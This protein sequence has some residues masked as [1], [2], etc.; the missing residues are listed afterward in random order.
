MKTKVAAMRKLV[1][2][3]TPERVS[4][5]GACLYHAIAARMILG[6]ECLILA[7]NASWKFTT[8]DDGTNPTHFSYVYTPGIYVPGSVMPEMHVWNYYEGKMLDITTCYW[9]A[10]C[11]KLIGEEFSQSLIPPDFHYGA[12]A[13]ETGLWYYEPSKDATQLAIQM[14][15]AIAREA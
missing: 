13:E 3:I 8:F 6:R 10:Q 12:A 7:G 15:N 1:K 5:E 4:L 11:L 14:L 2:Q 9:P